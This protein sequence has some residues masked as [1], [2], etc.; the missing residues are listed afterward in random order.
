MQ[1]SPENW[2]EEERAFLE[3]LDG[4]EVIEHADLQI[5]IGLMKAQVE[6]AKELLAARAK[7]T[8]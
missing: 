7:K 6:R 4:Q 1:S 3:R 2:S 8:N 5:L